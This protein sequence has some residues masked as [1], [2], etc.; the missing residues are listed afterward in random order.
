[1]FPIAHINLAILPEDQESSCPRCHSA[2]RQ[3]RES[4]PWPGQRRAHPHAVSARKQ[5]I[6]PNEGV[7]EFG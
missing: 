2:W 5:L 4:G 6:V 1:M 3:D 7:P